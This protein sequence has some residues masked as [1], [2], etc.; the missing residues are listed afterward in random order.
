MF[1]A[2]SAYSQPR[3]RVM[4]GTAFDLGDVREGIVVK[5]SL[6]VR[7]DGTQT[8]TISD[9]TTSCG[10]TTVKEGR[11]I[12]GPGESLVL[13]VTINSRGFR[14]RV[15]RE[16]RIA[17]NDP[18]S[19]MTIV[20]FR[21]VIRTDI[22]FVPSYVSF[23]EI[24]RGSMVTRSVMMYNR[25]GEKLKVKVSSEDRRVDAA[26]SAP[27]IAPGDSVLLRVTV[28]PKEAGELKGR[29]KIATS[30]KGSEDLQLSY[31]ARVR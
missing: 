28:R 9:V 15:R 27:A 26:V 2:V 6:T 30:R 23:G 7:N 24:A 11:R 8:L 4:E 29:L 21:S 22:E 25:S 18:S 13:P 16:V 1:A 17:S 10:C 3:L 19:P 5:R 14:G 31:I 20:E 12:L